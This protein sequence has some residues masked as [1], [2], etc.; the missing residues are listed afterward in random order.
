MTVVSVT[1]TIMLIT[2][3]AVQWLEGLVP[4]LMCEP[5]EKY[6]KRL[7]SISIPNLVKI[8]TD[9][10]KT[11]KRPSSSCECASGSSGSS[12]TATPTSLPLATCRLL[13][14][15][16]WA[17]DHVVE[18]THALTWIKNRWLEKHCENT[19]CAG[20]KK[21]VD[22]ASNKLWALSYGQFLPW[23]IFPFY[24]TCAK[25]YTVFG[26]SRAPSGLNGAVITLKRRQQSNPGSGEEDHG[27]WIFY[28]H[29]PSLTLPVECGAPL[30]AAIGVMVL[31]P[32]FQDMDAKRLF[33]CHTGCEVDIVAAE[34]WTNVGFA[35]PPGVK[36]T[37]E[38]CLKGLNGVSVLYLACCVL[39]MDDAC[40]K[41]LQMK[42]T[43]NMVLNDMIKRNF[44]G[45]LEVHAPVCLEALVSSAMQVSTEWCF[46][47]L[48]QRFSLWFR[49]WTNRP[50]A[51]RLLRQ[52]PLDLNRLTKDLL[53]LWTR[54]RTRKGFRV[55]APDTD[56]GW[57]NTAE[58]TA[59]GAFYGSVVGTVTLTS[60]KAI[61]MRME[62]MDKKKRNADLTAEWGKNAVAILTAV[63]KNSAAID[64]QATKEAYLNRVNEKIVSANTDELFSLSMYLH[65]IRSSLCSV[66]TSY[67]D[68][69]D[70]DRLHRGFQ[71]AFSC[72]TTQLAPIDTQT[73]L[74]FFSPGAAS[75]GTSSSVSVTTA[76]PVNGAVNTPTGSVVTG[77]G[78]TMPQ[79]QPLTSLRD[80]CVSHHSAS[81]GP[82]IFEDMASLKVHTY[83]S[84]YIK[85][86]PRFKSAWDGAHS[87]QSQISAGALLQQ[88]LQMSHSSPASLTQ[89]GP[90]SEAFRNAAQLALRAQQAQ[91]VQQ[92]HAQ[93]RRA[94]EAQEWKASCASHASAVV[95]LAL[96]AALIYSHLHP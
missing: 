46:Q 92:A 65:G 90:T 47:T 21:Y 64:L 89:L 49:V 5:V 29:R 76:S 40:A 15:T 53:A 60:L 96:L 71:Q 75:A 38:V 54:S 13:D 59:M 72:V 6:F 86:N 17:Y 57:E 4:C 18:S 31:E 44:V 78:A 14:E 69:L 77:T 88:C 91:R 26:P 30:T 62:K 67:E 55:F 33:A 83:T 25:N 85:T 68:H 34:D 39:R 20:W 52:S 37:K 84:E 32:T 19:L 87:A 94:Q 35:P 22:E 61:K 10:E 43:G 36:G 70:G 81:F 48:C 41:L 50:K 82:L 58:V 74:S 3:P 24:H 73:V 12:N 63:F 11:G 2:D 7:S 8:I 45:V 51:E 95:I 79:I 27:P 23:A 1:I 42:E 93:R 66:T 16:V 80:G 28:L 9:F 56:E